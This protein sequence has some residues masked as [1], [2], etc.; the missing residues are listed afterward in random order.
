MNYFVSPTG[1]DSN[2]G[3]SLDTP[4]LTLKYALEQVVSGD[5]LTIADGSYAAVGFGRPSTES[6]YASGY[7][8]VGV[9][10]T[11]GV[12]V[13]YRLLVPPQGSGAFD[14]ST[15]TAT[16]DDTGFVQL[17]LWQLS[18]YELWVGDGQHERFVTGTTNCSIPELLSGAR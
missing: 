14:G 11:P 12:K 1:S 8:Y 9:V 6:I 18:E 4:W 10:P 16:A 3:T 15:Q 7:V 13:C 2:N 5:T 17:P